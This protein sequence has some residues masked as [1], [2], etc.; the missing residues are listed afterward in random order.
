MRKALRFAGF[1]LGGV[2]VLLV[3][4]VAGIYAFSQPQLRHHY[5]V[6]VKPLPVPAQPDSALLARG[7]HVASI[8]GCTDCHG[9]DLAGGPM[10]ENAAMGRLYAANLTSGAGGIGGTFSIEDWDRAIRHGVGP[11]GR[12][13]MFMPAQEYWA[14]GDADMTALIAY[15]RSL[16]PVDRERPATRIGPMARMLLLAGKLPLV[17][18][19]LIDQTATRPAAPTESPTA[20]YGAYLA[21]GCRGCHGADYSG[22][23]IAGGDP[24][25]L[26]AANLTPDSTAGIGAWSEADFVR[27]LR[28]GRKPDGSEV[29]PPMPVAATRSMTDTELRALWAYLRTLPP[30]HGS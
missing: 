22:G 28:E 13:L 3:L 27:A 15:L 23:P 4:A 30:K 8:R 20:A 9:A 10:V 12:P 6:S 1:G 11:D 17:P 29:R 16:P 2:V 7:A 21:S 14:L 25:W 18:A 5:D 24:S 19:K 26:P